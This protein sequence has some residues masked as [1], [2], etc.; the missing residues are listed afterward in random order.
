MKWEYRS[1]PLDLFALDEWEEQLNR[2]GQDGWE[3]VCVLPSPDGFQHRA[4][5]K[6]G[7]SSIEGRT[8]IAAI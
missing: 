6:R 3:L 5:L 7:S 4:I 2:S 8:R 1:S